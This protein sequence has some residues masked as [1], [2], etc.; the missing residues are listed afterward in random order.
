M[1][2]VKRHSILKPLDLHGGFELKSRTNRCLSCG[3]TENIGRRRY[4]SVECRKKLH[5]K[6][7]TR[8][9]LI[10]ALNIRY[11][12]FCFSEEMIVMDMLPYGSVD[13]YS[14]F[15]P[16]S[17]GKKPAEDFGHMAD[18]LGGLW[19][20]E[21]RRTNKRYAASRYVLDQAFRNV[22][23]IPSVK[24]V[25]VKVPSI[26]GAALADLDIDKSVLTSPDLQKIVKD[27]YRRQAKE[28]HP[29]RGGDAIKFRNVYKAYQE[30][31]EWAKNPTF[32][33]E[34][35]FTH[36]WLYSGNTNRWKQPL[37]LR[38]STEDAR[39]RISW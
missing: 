22:I 27:A 4:C 8:T 20:D 2:D 29:D 10:R 38:K 25:T 32:V 16:R 21:K 13:T 12:T 39:L 11:A 1:P 26:K 37:P 30:L 14:F 35:G 7:D 33:M 3:T 19:W 5:Y 6:L 28:C 17:P 36:K 34:C 15:Y 23:P 18:L 9:G 24:P 31:L